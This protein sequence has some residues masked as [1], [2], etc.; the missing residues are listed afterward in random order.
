MQASPQEVDLLVLGAGAAGMTAALSAAVLGLDVLVVEKADVV[1]GTTARS[2]GAVWVPNSHHSP[3]GRDSPDKALAYLRG[4]VGNR[5]RA[6]MADA[7]LGTA[8]A[9]VRFLED[10]SQV[11]FRAFAHHPD[12]WPEVSGATTAGRVLEVLPFDAGVLGRDFVRL[13]APLPEFTLFGGMMVDRIDI[14]HL[15]NATRAP[16]S[17]AHA[18]RL[19]LRYG[20]DRVRHKRGT[21]LVMGNALA[22]RLFY[23]LKQRGVPV[24]TST[25]VIELIEENGRIAG[26]QLESAGGT[27]TV[28]SR[29]GVVLATGGLTRHPELRRRLSPALLSEHSPV[30]ES[31]TG[32][33]VSLGTGA[34]GHLSTDHAATS[35]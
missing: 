33:G 1:G 24:L 16:A 6:D 7:Y 11:R 25:R 15:L 5:L 31:A 13:R 22:G 29:R 3:P 10:N 2:A 19:M 34:G 20:A 30:I 9:M 26:A 17:F 27:F 18:A 12:Y 32:D 28:R 21:R 4:T 35:F 14:G 8:P 23:S